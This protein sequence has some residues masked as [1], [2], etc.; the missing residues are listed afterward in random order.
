[1]K[2]GSV[3]EVRAGHD[4]DLVNRASEAIGDAADGDARDR[5]A[6]ALSWSAGVGAQDEGEASELAEAL[7]G[8]W[9]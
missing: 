3:A 8:A 7:R 4:D 6:E 9:E 1:M 5:P 2:P